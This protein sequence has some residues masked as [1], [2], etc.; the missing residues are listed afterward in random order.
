MG[1]HDSAVWR[2]TWEGYPFASEFRDIPT[3]WVL[4][5]ESG[6]LAGTLNN[7]HMLYEMNGCR[8]RGAIAAG[9]AVDA[10]YRGKSLRLMSTFFK[11]GGI[12]VYL[13]VSANPATA[14]V[15]TGMKI[16]R[17]PIPG[18]GTPFLWAVRPRAFALATLYRRSLPGAAALSW[19]AGLLLGAWDLVRRSGR[20][21]PSFPVRRLDQFD[22]RL[23][24]LFRRLGAASPRIRAVR[25]RQVLAWR[26]RAEL[27]ERR[28]AILAAER[29]GALT[30]YAVLV[31]RNGSE[32]EMAMYDVADIQGVQDDPETIKDLL[33]ES[34]QI[35]REDRVD[36]LKFMT[37]LPGRRLLAEQLRPWTYSLPFWQQYFQTAT[38][39]V[40]AAL[41]TAEAWDFSLFDTF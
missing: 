4:E 8:L 6:A 11:Q 40:S 32:R 35:A 30:G 27:R 12:D 34:L 28:I 38:S 33:L 39:D 37:G 17:I 9:W 10:E 21:R 16:P 25:D 14:R 29:G 7:V 36:A 41:S 19:P 1:N 5:T 20:G 3:G 31:R 2:E 22:D 13:N 15:L 26:F 23:D 18:Y 24:P